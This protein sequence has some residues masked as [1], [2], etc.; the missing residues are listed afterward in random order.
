MLGF[1]SFVTDKY[2]LECVLSGLAGAAEVADSTRTSQGKPGEAQTH[3]WRG[4]GQ[5]QPAHPHSHTHAFTMRVIPLWEVH[6]NI[7][8]Y[9]F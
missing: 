9:L 4:G 7:F 3:R 8:P 6:L 2:N 5:G 1:T